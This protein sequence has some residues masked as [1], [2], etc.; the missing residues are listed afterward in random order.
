VTGRLFYFVR[1]GETEWNAEQRLQGQLDVPLNEH[2]R[3]QA[4]HCATTLA[5]LLA[6]TGHAAESFVYLS[7]PLARARETME[8]LRGGLG[9]A[10]QD[11]AV[12]P[13]L[14]EMSFGDWEGLTYKE[15]RVRDP[16]ALPARERDKWNYQ[17]PGGESYAQLL[18]RVEAWHAG[19]TSDAIVTAHGGVARALMVLFKVRTPADAPGGDIPQG[20]V[21]EFAPGVVHCHR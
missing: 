11:Y 12:D 8:I 17:V 20:V 1:H 15:V 21:Y 6:R 18:V 14:A 4:A 16:A 19:I 10:P 9:L 3:G 5:R 2:G 7:S 13:R